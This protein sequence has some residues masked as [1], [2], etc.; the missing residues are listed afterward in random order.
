MSF[1]SKLGNLATD[2]ALPAISVG[3]S[4]LAGGGNPFVGEALKK[5]LLTMGTA[6][7]GS[8]A[9]GKEEERMRKAQRQAQQNQARANLINVI[10]PS[11]RAQARPVEMPKAGLLEKGA[12]AL[13]YG[14]DVYQKAQMAAQA[15]QEM[16]NRLEIQ[17]REKLQ[18]E[19]QDAFLAERAK[20]PTT[21][22]EGTSVSPLAPPPGASADPMLIGP[23]VGKGTAPIT[24]PAGMPASFKSVVE[25][26]PPAGDAPGR[27]KSVT[28]AGAAP[29]A[30]PPGADALPVGGPPMA[31]GPDAPYE[32]RIGPLPVTKGALTNPFDPDT[33]PVRHAAFEEA[34][35]N[36]LA[37]QAVS[38]RADK[39]LK[40]AE[41]TYELAKKRY[42]NEVKTLG[43]ASKKA[44]QEREMQK[45]NLYRQLKDKAIDRVGDGGDPYIA[46]TFFRQSVQDSP[47]HGNLVERDYKNFLGEL[48]KYSPDMQLSNEQVIYISRRA[49]I[50]DGIMAIR[51]EIL[52]ADPKIF[53]LGEAYLNAALFKIAGGKWADEDARDLINKLNIQSE[54]GVRLLSGAAITESEFERFNEDFIGGLLGGRD[55]LLGRL[56]NIETAFRQQRESLIEI[57][58]DPDAPAGLYKLSKDKLFELLLLERETG[59]RTM[60]EEV[61]RRGLSTE[62]IEWHKARSQTD[63]ESPTTK[64]PP[65]SLN[66]LLPPRGGGIMNGLGQSGVMSYA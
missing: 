6:G 29:I 43:V 11:A 12:R 41:D 35:Y 56:D 2:L 14:L 15:A 50:E 34:R 65:T 8:F 18:Q 19:A 21:Y 27:F 66:Y 33:Q 48:A 16:K 37:E 5:T 61:A 44:A 9:R 7:L 62:F 52:Q 58:Q 38:E 22:I 46:F 36:W 55:A 64:G 10:N 4:A 1:L 59:S 23:T 42:D 45:Y 54:M 17:A 49:A 47:L 32:Q 53:E 63:N 60:T 24:P 57:A 26:E 40:I 51:E 39:R 20:G 13:P 3:A 25:G 28:G 31:V 30:I